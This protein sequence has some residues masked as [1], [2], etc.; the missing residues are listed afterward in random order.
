MADEDNI[1]DGIF[2]PPGSIGA[3][4]ADM[5]AGV[6][7]ILRGLQRRETKTQ[8]SN[9]ARA[10]SAK[11]SKMTRE[12]DP[13]VKEQMARGLMRSQEFLEKHPQ[14][15]APMMKQAEK[16]SDEFKRAIVVGNRPDATAAER[17]TATELLSEFARTPEAV[18]IL[19]QFN[20]IDYSNLSPD[21]ITKL[22]KPIIQQLTESVKQ[23]FI[24]Q[25]LEGFGAEDLPP[26][27]K[28]ATFLTGGD[29][30]A[31]RGVLQKKFQQETDIKTEDFLGK[32]QERLRE[33]DKPI[34]PPEAAAKLELAEEGLRV[35][36]EAETAIGKGSGLE[37]VVAANISGFNEDFKSAV[38][39][40][41]ENRLRLVSGAMVKEEEIDDKKKI[42]MGVLKTNKQ[43]L[44]QFKQEQRYFAG[45]VRR[46]Q[47]G[48]GFPI[49]PS[50]EEGTRQKGE[51]KKSNINFENLENLRFG[52]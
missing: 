26:E 4:F 37:A 7:S 20:Q 1:Q 8:Y 18:Q 10:W 30:P 19:S 50:K 49:T 47:K 48:F 43:L 3:G 13:A 29:I 45:V 22:T 27:A 15:I 16:A 40:M 5:G 21:E 11:W 42:I 41:V 51:Q 31:A 46:S 14:M 39:Q 17:L 35:A 9:F 38:G 2:G 52:R 28:E 6:G 44:K 34:I 32:K 23:S 25:S 24:S 33:A 12:P 36:E